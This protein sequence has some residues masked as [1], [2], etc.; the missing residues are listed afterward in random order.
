[1]P[2]YVLNTLFFDAMF[3]KN[4][5]NSDSVMPSVYLPIFIPSERRMASGT[6]ASMRWSSVLKPVTASMASTSALEPLLWRGTKSS[7]GLSA[8]MAMPRRPDAAKEEA[9]GAR[10]SGCAAAPALEHD[11]RTLAERA[12]DATRRV[13]QLAPLMSNSLIVC[14]PSSRVPAAAERSAAAARRTPLRALMTVVAATISHTRARRARGWI[15]AQEGE[16]RRAGRLL[17]GEHQPI[18]GT[19]PRKRR[20]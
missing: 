8:S 12:D 10:H 14:R 11:P 1:M 17:R 3:L 7:L 5:R 19:D 6:V 16:R 15:G 4:S 20:I 18:V 9:A 2:I 13:G